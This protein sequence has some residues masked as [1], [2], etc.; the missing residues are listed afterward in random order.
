MSENTK[1]QIYH[2]IR[3]IEMNNAVTVNTKKT[4][5]GLDIQLHSFLSLTQDQSWS[6]W[7]NGRFNLGDWDPGIT[8]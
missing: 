6:T 7:H 1:Q 2:N 3:E 8:D 4:Y 5:W